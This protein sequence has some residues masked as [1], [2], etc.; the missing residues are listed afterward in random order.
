MGSERSTAVIEVLA[1]A[2]IVDLT[3]KFPN[4]QKD[5]L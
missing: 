2:P 3:L 1:E 4:D 5:T